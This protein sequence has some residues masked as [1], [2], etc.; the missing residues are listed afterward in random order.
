MSGISSLEAFL[1]ERI[2]VTTAQ[3]SM[4]SNLRALQ[5]SWCG[6]LLLAIHYTHLIKVLC[7]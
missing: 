4:R 2:R 6:S 7:D 3:G 1:H 5:A